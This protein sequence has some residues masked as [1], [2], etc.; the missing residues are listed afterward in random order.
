MAEPIGTCIVFLMSLPVL[1]FLVPL[2]CICHPLWLV[3]FP[4]LTLLMFLA[5]I[6]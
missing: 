6:L 2:S 4:L 1:F 5:V 3:T